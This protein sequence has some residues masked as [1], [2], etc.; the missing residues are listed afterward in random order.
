M[1]ASYPKFKSALNNVATL[2]LTGPCKLTSIVG[3]NTNAAIEYLQ[4]FDAAAAGSV[5]VGTT[6]PTVAIGL[7]AS[8]PFNFAFGDFGLGFNLG[9]VVAATTTFNG[10]TSPGVALP[11]TFAIRSE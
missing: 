1:D 6:P 11:V 9:L 3:L 4:L 7:T 5:T 10:G 8:V 2:L